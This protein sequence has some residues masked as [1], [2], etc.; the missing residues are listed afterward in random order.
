MKIVVC[1][2]CGDFV[3]LRPSL[4]SCCSCGQAGGVYRGDREALYS[5]PDGTSVIG[6]HA[7]SFTTAV[8]HDQQDRRNHVER[9]LGHELKAFTIPWNAPTIKRVPTSRIF[10]ER[11]QYDIHWTVLYEGG[12]IT[13]FKN[14]ANS[15]RWTYV[16]LE[17]EG[18]QDDG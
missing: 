14:H 12:T 13:K 9:D 18:H 1:G 8:G 2:D 15:S 11:K 17:D 10:D 6:M 4:W 16:V 7:G 3:R 5:G